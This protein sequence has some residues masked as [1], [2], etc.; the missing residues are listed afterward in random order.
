LRGIA[1]RRTRR[2]G[3]GHL[4]H[5]DHRPRPALLQKGKA[6]LALKQTLVTVLRHPADACEMALP[7]LRQAFFMPEKRPGRLEDDRDDE[8]RCDQTWY[9]ISGMTRFF[10]IIHC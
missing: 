8:S 10:A 1:G 9:E 6:G 7:P 3:T 4:G 5:Y 2:G